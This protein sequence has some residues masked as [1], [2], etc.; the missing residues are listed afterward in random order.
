MTNRVVG[1]PFDRAKREVEHSRGVKGAAARLK[2]SPFLSADIAQNSGQ[3]SLAYSTRQLK[4]PT[5]WKSL[6]RIDES[7][8]C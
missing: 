6:D 1:A 4:H 2:A 7:S 3:L 8:G 5:S